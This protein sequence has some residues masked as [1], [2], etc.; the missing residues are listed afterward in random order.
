MQSGKAYWREGLGWIIQPDMPMNLEHVA[1]LNNGSLEGVPIEFEMPDPRRARPKQRRLFFALL[2][3][4]HR[5]SGEPVEWLKEYFY[6]MYTVKTA[7]KEISLANDTNNTVSDA[8]ELIDQVI[9]FIF[10]WSVPIRDGYTLLPRDEEHFIYE[11]LIHRQCVICGRHADLHHVDYG[12]GNNTVGMG[13][14]RNKVDHSKRELYPL[15]REHHQEIETIN[16]TAFENKY[17]IKVKGI[18]LTPDVLRKLG[19]KGEY[20]DDTNH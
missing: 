8:V 16:T 13:M 7:G 1:T 14:N 6:T 15:C 3:D 18:K 20:D 12:M 17:R 19:V 2:G 10:D 4:I 11:C 9:D 5:W